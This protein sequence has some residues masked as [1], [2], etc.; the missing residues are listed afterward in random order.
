MDRQLTLQFWYYIVVILACIFIYSFSTII[1]NIIL[2]LKLPG[3]PT[4]PFIG[5][6]GLITDRNCKCLFFC[7][8]Y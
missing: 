1:K 7:S 5:N 6:I 4:I 8:T 3:P 2:A